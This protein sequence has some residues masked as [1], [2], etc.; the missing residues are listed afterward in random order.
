MTCRGAKA[1]VNYLN[2]ITYG[3]SNQ[4]RLPSTGNNPQ[5]GFNQTDSELGQLFY[6]E[7]GGLKSSPILDTNTFIN[8]Q[9][10]T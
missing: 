3:G 7:L 8:E 1:F 10:L 9:A 6:S 4:W 2:N 5:T